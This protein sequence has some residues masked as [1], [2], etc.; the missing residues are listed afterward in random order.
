MNFNR[1]KF[2]EW[3]KQRP[4]WDG[5]ER[6]MAWVGWQR[7][8]LAARHT[9]RELEDATRLCEKHRPNGGVRAMCLICAGLK[10]QAA[11]S[12]VSY[13]C[14]EPN[15][16]E[17]SAYDVHADEDAVIEQVKRLKADAVVLRDALTKAADTFADYSKVLRLIGKDVLAQGC[18]IAEQSTRAALASTEG[19][20]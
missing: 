2:D 8:W 16:M 11:L 15:E 14:E 3:A 12:R 18:D 1:E 20:A 4:N 7:G 6:S 13:A 19:G 10:L 17:C 9:L 5:S